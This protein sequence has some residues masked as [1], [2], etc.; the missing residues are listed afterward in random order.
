MEIDKSFDAEML[1][2]KILNPNWLPWIGKD[3]N[4]ITDKRILIVGESNYLTEDVDVT[5]KDYIR[6]LIEKD[7]TH[8]G[9]YEANKFIARRHLKLEKILSVNI[10]IEAEK[11]TFWHNA[12][13][14]NF[15]QTPLESRMEKDRPHFS[16]YL[17]GWEV[18][19]Q[20]LDILKPR[21]CIMNGVNSYNHFYEDTAE[22][23]GYFT[24]EKNILN[25]IGNAY[26]RKILLKNKNFG[27]RIKVLFIKHSS[28]PMKI[29]NWN[30]FITSELK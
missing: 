11:R 22:A 14:Y 15:I 9:W 5:Q 20:L 26:P 2:I 29:E 23:F 17:E 8:M 18:F 6:K 21:Y 27:N 4:S 30:K 3:F 24:M 28:L 25:K 7:G 13:Y 1:R 19:F 16:L 10:D 12:A